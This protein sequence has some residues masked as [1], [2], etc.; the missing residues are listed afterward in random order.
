[1]VRVIPKGVGIKPS[2]VTPNKMAIPPSNPAIV[3]LRAFGK[4][5]LSFL[6]KRSSHLCHLRSE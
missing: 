4:L 3:I 5:P 6:Y 1:M 2:E